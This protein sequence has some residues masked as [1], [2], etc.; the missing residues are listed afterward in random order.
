VRRTVEEIQLHTGV[1]D[2]LGKRD[3]K[4]VLRLSPS[5]LDFVC[6]MGNGWTMISTSVE[7]EKR[8]SQC[9][10]GGGAKGFLFS[11][12]FCIC[13]PGVTA[14]VDILLE[15][16]TD[17]LLLCSS[18]VVLPFSSWRECV[19]PIHGASCSV[20]VVVVCPSVWRRSAY[21]DTPLLS[22]QIS[23]SSL[24]ASP[25]KCLERETTLRKELKK[26]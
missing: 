14:L 2:R 16:H 3:T 26:S 7:R 13:V 4:C 20:V 5:Y 9:L 6:N 18:F 17:T 10:F 11:S 15:S 23:S 21:K 22:K 24:F 19:Q 25:K 1:S 8:K 12:F